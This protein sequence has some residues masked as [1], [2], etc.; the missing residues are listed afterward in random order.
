[1]KLDCGDRDCFQRYNQPVKGV[2][3]PEIIA[4]LTAMKTVTLQSLFAGGPSGNFS[5]SDIGNWIEQVKI[6][7]PQFVQIYTLDRGTPSKEIYPADH[8][9][10]EKLGQHLR[11]EGIPCRVFTRQ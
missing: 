8:E 5:E 4:G 9:K 1:M 3:F 10:L 7:R 6:I 11:E 2:K